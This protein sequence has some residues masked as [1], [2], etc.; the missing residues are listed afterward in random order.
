MEVYINIYDIEQ[1][2]NA[3]IS[4]KKLAIENED[5]KLINIQIIAGQ[6]ARKKF[7]ILC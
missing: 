5:M 3:M 6:N 4:Q 1:D 7:N 2:G